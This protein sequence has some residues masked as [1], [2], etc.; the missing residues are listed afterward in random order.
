MKSFEKIAEAI[1]EAFYRSGIYADAWD[2]IDRSDQL[3]WIAAVMAANKEI[4]E[5]H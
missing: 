2:E 4:T 3:R 1:Y 5:V